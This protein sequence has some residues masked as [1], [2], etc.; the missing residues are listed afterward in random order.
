MNS[1]I[2]EFSLVNFR[3]GLASEGVILEQTREGP[4]NKLFFRGYEPHIASH[5]K[6]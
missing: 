1:E 6:F 3:F 2:M 5:F 4:Q